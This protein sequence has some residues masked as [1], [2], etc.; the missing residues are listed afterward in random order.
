MRLALYLVRAT[1]RQ[2][3]RLTLVVALIGGLLGTVTLGAI[4]AA[5]RTDSAYGRYLRSVDASDVLVDIPGPVLPIVREIEHEPGTLST[6]TWLG[7]NAQ[8]VIHGKVDFSYL[9]DNLQGSLDGEYYRQDKVTVLSGRMPPADS[10]GELALSQSM[11]SAFGLKVGDHMT[12]QFYREPLYHGLPTDVNPTPIQPQVTF[13]VA[14]IVSVPPALADTFDEVPTAIMSPAQ[15]AQYIGNVHWTGWAFA[16]VAMRLRNGDAGVPALQ[17]HLTELERA[18]HAAYGVNVTFT[19]RRMAAVHREAQQGI[20]PQALAV[21]A[22][23]ALAALALLV[24]MTQGLA[25][26]LSRSASV[27]PVARALGAGRLE[28]AAAVAAWG[29]IA[30]IGAAAA[31]VAGAIAVSPLGPVGPVRQYDPLRGVQL[32]WLVLGAGGAALLVAMLAALAWLAWRAVQPDRAGSASQGAGRMAAAARAGLPV[33]VLTGI[34]H[35]LDPGTGPRRVPVRATMAGS[36]VAVTALV[37]A[38]VFGSSLNGLTTHPARY[39]WNWNVAVQATGG[40]GTFTPG[41]LN[42]IVKGQ[43]GVQGWSQFGFGQ[44]SIDGSEIPAMGLETEP[45]R[46]VVEPPTTAGHPL[47][48]GDQIELGTLT[49]RQLGVHIGSTVRVAGYAAPLTVVGAVTLP[50]FGTGLTDHPSLGRGAMLDE[51]TLLAAL[52]LPVHPSEKQLN[53]TVS[54]TAYPGTAAFDVSG[55]SAR[56]RLAA[57]IIKQGDAQLDSAGSYYTLP[58]ELGASVRDASQMGSQPLALAAAVAA[59]AVLALVLTIMASVR[60]R[61]R[62]LALLKA[63]GLRTR[64][65][66]AVVGW[67]TTTLLLI[68]IAVGVPLG[69]AVGNWTWTSFANSIGVVPLPVVPVIS[70]AAGLAVLLVAGNLLA[71]LP[72]GVAARIHP[73]ATFRTE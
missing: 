22:F 60:Q 12:W 53:T 36:V 5:R 15:T 39:G 3:W 17:H 13:T 18:I 31:S 38:L 10:T 58:P 49:M 26:L 62:E 20:E 1:W 27:A 55:A 70:L 67:Q 30:V 11:A 34:R 68:A 14:A 71:L 48:G 23:G 25:Q 29:V 64:Q 50:A 24:L 51:P 21:A 28:A 7:M 69:V 43:K 47:G 73:A 56:R 35:A 6:A 61:R 8:P 57:T 54:S 16:W 46:V 45:G 52:D 42:K 40:W 4:A 9:T 66:R 37:A 63:L 32:D 65:I 19:F 44:L 72:A 33:T 59:A 2:S 41:W